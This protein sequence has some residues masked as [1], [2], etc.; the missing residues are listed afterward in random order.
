M[1]LQTDPLA[2]TEPSVESSSDSIGDALPRC[3]CR[4]DDGAVFA[5]AE[6]GHEFIRASDRELWAVE[7]DDALVSVRSGA[8]LAYRRGRVYFAQENGEPLYYERAV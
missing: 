8:V 5:Y 2:T 4:F 6:R 3:L 1:A 7:R